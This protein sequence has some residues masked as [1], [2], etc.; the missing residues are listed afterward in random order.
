MILR[1]EGTLT[2]TGFTV[3]LRALPVLVV[4]NVNVGSMTVCAL[5]CFVS[6]H[7]VHHEARVPLLSRALDGDGYFPQTRGGRRVRR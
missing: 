3:E 6:Q 1:V 2:S 7:G 5:L 4:E